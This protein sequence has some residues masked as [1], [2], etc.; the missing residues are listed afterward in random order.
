MIERF[1]QQGL[2]R[3]HAPEREVGAPAF[4]DTIEAQVWTELI[5]SSDIFNRAKRLIRDDVCGRLRG[6]RGAL[7]LLGPTGVGKSQA[8]AW[9]HKLSP[10]RGQPWVRLDL[11]QHEPDLLAAHLFGHGPGAFT[12]SRRGGAPGLIEEA[13]L[14]TLCIEEIDAAPREVQAKLLTITEEGTYRRVGETEVRHVKCRLIVTSQVLAGTDPEMLERRF[15]EDLWYR[16]QPKVWMPTL[17]S[18]GDDLIE[19]AEHFVATLGEGAYELTPAG[20]QV[21]FEHTWPGDVRELRVVISQAL[22]NARLLGLTCL[23]DAGMDATLRAW[24]GEQRAKTQETITLD[25]LEAAERLSRELSEAHD[26]SHG[27]WAPQEFVK[28]SHLARSRCGE[29]LQE[30]RKAGAIEAI[31]ITRDRRYRWRGYSKRMCTTFGRMPRSA[32]VDRVARRSQCP[33]C[34]HQGWGEHQKTRGDA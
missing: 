12:G 8:S 13:D 23:D 20:G 14:G 11:A 17:A 24:L 4:R 30:L 1:D 27:W 29:L 18:R 15:R 21:L 19:L 16:L 34:G 6:R 25:P 28:N 9:A 10:R 2:K 31:G 5:G 22:T 7:T 3:N 32:S 33:R 26:A